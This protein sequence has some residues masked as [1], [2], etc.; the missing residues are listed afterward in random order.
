[1]TIEKT[2]TISCDWCGKSQ[3]IDEDDRAYDNPFVER[4]GEDLCA[5]CDV[6]RA[7]AIADVKAARKRPK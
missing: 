5:S 6:A 1:M 3:V 2:C 7:N 4:E